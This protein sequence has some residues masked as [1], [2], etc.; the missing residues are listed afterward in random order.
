M[1]KNKISIIEKEIFMSLM[2][3]LCIS[4]I[5]AFVVSSTYWSGNPLKLYAGQ[6]ENFTIILQNAGGTSDL[7]LKAAISESSE[8]LKLID[9]SDVYVVPAG[10]RTTVNLEAVIP[11]DAQS[12]K[13]YHA[14]IDF[15]ETLSEAGGTTFGSSIGQS[16]D[17]IVLEE[18][19]GDKPILRTALILCISGIIIILLIIALVI[20]LKKK[21]SKQKKK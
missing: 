18:S 2:I 9:T 5:S 12:G 6:T 10:G 4:N 20:K 14:K 19:K 7:T 1:K 8:V 3:L 11:E 13:I 15:T 17:I 21:N 16:F